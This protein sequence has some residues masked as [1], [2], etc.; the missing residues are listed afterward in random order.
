M[1]NLTFTILCLQPGMIKRTVFSL[2]FRL[3]IIFA[4]SS[5]RT[6]SLSPSE[7]ILINEICCYDA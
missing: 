2:A 5:I 3:L 1:A 7:I 6:N 4:F